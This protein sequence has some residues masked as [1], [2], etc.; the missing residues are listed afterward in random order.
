MLYRVAVNRRESRVVVTNASGRWKGAR[1]ALVEKRP[2]IDA[3]F[4]ASD[5]PKALEWPERVTAGRWAIR[6][7]VEANYLDG[8][9]STATRELNQASAEMKRVFEPHLKELDP[10][11]EEESG[12]LSDDV[13]G[14]D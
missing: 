11:L 3:D 2:E 6:Y 1:A 4:R 13:L 12:D 9:D 8:T 5:L 7:T 10:G 14:I